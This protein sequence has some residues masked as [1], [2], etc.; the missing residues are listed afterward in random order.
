M[1]MHKEVLLSLKSS[2]QK[3]LI[4]IGSRSRT[5]LRGRPWS[6][7]T[8]SR[9]TVV[10]LNAVNWGGRASKWIPFEK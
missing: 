9:N 8:V 10:T 2:F 7:Q 3:E 5:R 1:L 4:K 6:L